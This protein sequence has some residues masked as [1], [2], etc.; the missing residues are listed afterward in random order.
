MN[1]VLDTNILLIY[2]RDQETKKAIE[3]NYKLFSN[4]NNLVIS[5][6][7]LGEIKSIAKRN[8][9]GV[10]KL[11]VVETLLNKLI[12][13]GISFEEMIETYAE[14]DTFSQGKHQTKKLDLSARNM[15]KNDLWIASTAVVTSSKLIT[16]DID[17]QHLTGVYLDLVLVKQVSKQK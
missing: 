8:K 3:S 14:I 17:F 7:T 12:V 5:T 11:A 10:K 6:V 4:N 15:G 1:Y 9:W 16:T 2:L 13:V